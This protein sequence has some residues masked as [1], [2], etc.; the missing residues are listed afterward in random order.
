MPLFA[1]PTLNHP[2]GKGREKD[3][4]HEKAVQNPGQRPEMPPQKGGI[5]RS[6]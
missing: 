1:A 6:S 5:S 3:V 2:Q 4:A